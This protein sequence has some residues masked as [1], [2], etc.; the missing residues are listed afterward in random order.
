MNL[1]RKLV[2]ILVVCFFTAI[3]FS[4]VFLSISLSNIRDGTDE[5]AYLSGKTRKMH[6]KTNGPNEAETPVDWK[7][8]IPKYYDQVDLREWS[9][10][11]HNKP[12]GLTPATGGNGTA[13]ISMPQIDP[14]AEELIKEH[15]YN[16]A[17]TERLPLQRSLP[18]YRCAEC[19]REM[20]PAALPAASI[21]VTFH[22]E[23]WSL[24]FRCIWSIIDRSPHELIDEI[25]LVD[26]ASTWTILKRPLADYVEMLP[27]PVKLIRTE[28]REGPIRARLIGAKEAK[29]LDFLWFSSN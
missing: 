28:K 6:V 21:V 4:L 29:V 15:G 18:D 3:L 17:A 14:K 27:V 24:I 5:F 11:K 20:Y 13:S 1:P 7:F 23:A 9:Q 12:K 19:K 2:Y 26:D 8:H 10:S 16:L 25:I 22:N